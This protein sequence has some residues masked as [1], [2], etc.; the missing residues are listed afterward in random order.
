M[1]SKKGLLSQ[2]TLMFIEKAVEFFGE[3]IF[4]RI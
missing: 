2:P 1:T 3:K 4:S